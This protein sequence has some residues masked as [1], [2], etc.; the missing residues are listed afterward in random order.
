MFKWNTKNIIYAT[1]G[2]K[3]GNYDERIYSSNISIDT[4]TLK[5][6]DVF[7]ALKGENFDGHVFLGEA[8]LKGAVIAIVRECSNY[9]TSFPLILV[10]DTLKALHDMASYYIKNVLIRAKV[11]AITGSIGKTTT[12]DMLNIVLS[13]YGISHAN[14]GNLNNDI[15]LPLTILKASE[16]CQYL[17]LEMGMSKANEIRK[18]SEIS[19]PDIAVITNVEPTHIENFSS[20]LD[21]AEAKSEIL[22]GMKNDGILIINRDNRYYNYFLSFCNKRKVVSFGK[23][24][25]AT[26]RLLDLARDDNYGLS[27]KIRFSDNTVINCNLLV[28][29]EHFVYSVL[30]IAVILQSLSLDLLKFPFTLKKFNITRGRGS[31]HKLKFNGK[32]I[33]LIDDSYNASPSSVKAAIKTLCT[34]SSHR[35]VALLGDMLELGNKSIKFHVGL[36]NSIVECCVNGVYTVGKF[37]LEL[38]RFLPENIRGMHFD[39]SSELRDYLPNIIQNNDVVLIKGSHKMKMDL[40]V[41]RFMNDC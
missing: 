14:K 38:Q 3:I 13:Q 31:F 8:F 23:H 25:S 21:I 27:F 32:N 7:I 11:I 4:R 41:R 17:I 39:N 2:K 37:M 20:L 5:R 10:Q 29:G 28:R 1:G 15:G 19:S 26:V 22:Y 36:L 12:K 24:R 6:G 33:Y 35:K 30:I 18:L 9:N 16:N 34:Y 40:I